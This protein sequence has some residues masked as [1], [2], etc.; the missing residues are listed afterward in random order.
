[1]R[2]DE[3]PGQPRTKIFGT[4]IGECGQS[5]SQSLYHL[6]RILSDI[7]SHFFITPNKEISS[8]TIDAS[9]ERI[10]I[11]LLPPQLP[12]GR[13]FDRSRRSSFTGL[14]LLGHLASVVHYRGQKCSLELTRILS[15]SQDPG[16]R[17]L[18]STEETASGR[19]EIKRPDRV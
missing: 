17:R 15:L 11:I 16:A 18:S 19:Y 2:P 14:W 1:M 9:Q 7:R 8:G 6:N 3:T 5:I 12:G 10:R 4:H 13:G